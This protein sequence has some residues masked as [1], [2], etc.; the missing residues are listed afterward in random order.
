MFDDGNNNSRRRSSIVND[1]MFVNFMR[2]ILGRFECYT[3]KSTKE[4]H[5]QE[6]DLEIQAD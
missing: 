2:L 6:L 1:D 3:Q 5:L 4:Q